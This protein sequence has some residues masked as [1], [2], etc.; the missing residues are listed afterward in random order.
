MDII[1][2]ISVVIGAILQ[3]ITISTIF[4]KPIRK[5]LATWIVKVSKSNELSEK[6]GQIDDDI[7]LIQNQIASLN[8]RVE[9]EKKAMQAALRDRILNIYYKY[10]PLK[11]MPAYARQ[12]LTL[13]K[14]IYIDNMHGNSF[15]QEVCDEMSRWETL[16]D[17]EFAEKYHTAKG[18]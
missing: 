13:L 9:V 17:V 18:G 11:E 1:K 10:L 4:I 15:V 7:F 6:L 5:I 8:E 2:N 14:E 3:I 12:N 16:S